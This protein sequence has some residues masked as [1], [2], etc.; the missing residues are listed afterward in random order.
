MACFGRTEGV[1]DYFAV[2]A[3]A[4][5]V[6][7]M[8][9]HRGVLYG[10]SAYGLW[11]LIPLYFKAVADVSP[12]EVLAHRA[13]W[14]FVLLAVLVRLLG[15]WGELWRELHDPKLMGILALNSVLIGGNWL[16]FIYAVGTGQTVQASL[17]YF[18]NP[19]VNV[20]LGV[21]F[22]HERL[23]PYQMLSI[24]LAAVGV[25]VLTWWVGHVP[26][27][28]LILVTT[29]AFYALMRKMTPV[30][31]LASVTVETLLM[32]P[33]ALGYLGYLA[34]TDRMTGSGAPTV[35]L[36]MLSGLVTTVPLLFFAAAARRLPLSTLGILQYLTPTL[37]F[38]VAV[39]VFG[40]PFSRA[41]LASF[42]CI[43]AA[44]G[45]YTADSFRAARQAR[46]DTDGLAVEP[47]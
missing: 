18:I 39:V 27:I 12:P 30:D 36:L 23:R 46:I 17:G 5:V 33:L 43:W 41:Q 9:S 14:S 22:L 4:T 40:E 25:V 42:C 2:K 37:Q 13:L 10:I 29:F 34:A 45:I 8:A 6:A 15:R 21:A 1:A 38:L 16:T 26:W 7:P 3:E 44:L 32:T 11:G 24:A 19:L 35:G 47:P 28:A 31:G 20:L